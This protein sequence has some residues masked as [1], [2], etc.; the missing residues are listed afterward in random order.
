MAKKAVC[1]GIDEYAE[2][3]IPRLSGCRS[4]ARAVATALSQRFGFPEAD[5]KL[6]LDAQ[7]TREAIL[8]SLDWMLM[9]A[10][11]GDV[12]VLYAACYGTV[13]PDRGNPN[14]L[15]EVLVTHDHSFQFSQ[16]RDDE[17]AEKLKRLPQGVLATVILDAG[18]LGPMPVPTGPM[19]F[20]AP[21]ETHGRFLAPPT[22]LPALA[23][24][25]MRPLPLAPRLRSRRADDPPYLTIFSCG[26]GEVARESSAGGAFTV[27]ML[28]A[29]GGG[30]GLPWDEIVRLAGQRIQS[31]GGQ[32]SPSCVVPHPMRS[33]PPFG[34]ASAGPPAGGGGFAATGASAGAPL[35]NYGHIPSFGSG[36]APVTAPASSGPGMVGM[37]VAGAAAVGVAAAG[38]AA[39]NSWGGGGG[40]Q[41]H[42][43]AG[44]MAPAASP[45]VLVVGGGNPIDQALG[46]FSDSDATVRACNA[47][48]KVIP[49]APVLVPYRSLGEAMR[50]LY[51]QADAAVAQRVMNLATS[52]DIASALKALS[53]VDTTSTGIALFSGLKGALGLLR[54]QGMNALE[55]DTQ[56]G[57][58]AALKLLAIAYAVSH[59]Y[60]GPIPGR[61]Q[62]F[63]TT[64]AGQQLSMYYAAM[65]V[66]LPFAD[67]AVAVAGNLVGNLM[68]RYG[69]EASGKLGAV[70][71]GGAAGEAQGILGALLSP[72]E[73]VVQRVTPYAKQAANAVGQHMPGVLNVADK[74]AGVVA[75]GLDVLP[76]YKYLGARAAAEACVLVA[77][78]GM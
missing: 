56:Q 9:T 27:A 20:G 55:T 69:G 24:L 16:L 43:P 7:A 40:Q 14:E 12:L 15:D 65:D 36:A 74:V 51:P 28:E 70:V 10:A 42:A 46:Q 44:S 62:L 11:P 49:F 53:M 5:V 2:R 58:D 47:L 45:A 71:G 52:E 54:G 4:D 38:V 1:V 35:P 8:R 31:F 29:L 73:G 41:V 50:A 21:L 72:I 59:L 22:D 25:R 76:I 32:Q 17:L 61:V 75:T 78:R 64:P 23:S 39:V 19:M 3:T 34:G 63:H 33:A 37:M 30:Q 13:M 68:N 77:S 57:V 26:E 67:N 48:F 60:P 66:A 6:L 18:R